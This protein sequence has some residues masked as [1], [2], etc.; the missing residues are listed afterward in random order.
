MDGWMRNRA[1]LFAHPQEQPLRAPTSF[2]CNFRFES[3]YEA[4]SLGFRNQSRIFSL[5]MSPIPSRAQIAPETPC[6]TICLRNPCNLCRRCSGESLTLSA[7]APS[8]NRRV[9]RL[10]C[11]TKRLAC[12]VAVPRPFLLVLAGMTNLESRCT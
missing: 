3:L 6:L 7:F 8:M 5:I 9:W 1:T 2:L 10:G 11:N 4:F 12:F